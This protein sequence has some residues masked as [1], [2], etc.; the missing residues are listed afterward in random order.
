M[1]VSLCTSSQIEDLSQ[2]NTKQNRK[3]QQLKQREGQRGIAREQRM[4]CGFE[5]D[6][7]SSALEQPISALSGETSSQRRIV[8]AQLRHP[9][10]LLCLAAFRG[11]RLRQRSSGGA[12]E[13]NRGGA[14]F[15]RKEYLTVRAALDTTRLFYSCFCVAVFP[16]PELRRDTTEGVD[17]F[18][19]TPRPP[20]FPFP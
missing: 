20:C 3:K 1:C 16:V 4:G 5:L 14:L 13:H 6:P 10:H 7:A 17:V 18:F 11:L 8:P 2:R 15:V 12:R 19:I 9:A